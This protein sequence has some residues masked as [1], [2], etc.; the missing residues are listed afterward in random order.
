MS[1]IGVLVC[2]CGLA[3][4]TCDDPNTRSTGQPAATTAPDSSNEQ[5]IRAASAAF[6]RAYNA[7]DV[8]A[9]A[10]LFTEDAEC[11]DEHG[12]LISG[13]KS[14]TENFAAKPGGNMEVEIDSIRFLTPEV[15]KEEGR[16]TIKPDGSGPPEVSR[17]TVL[18]VH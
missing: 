15:A 12:N 17:Y 6:V 7:G 18:Y 16:C 10:T 1:F 9:L 3:L 4:G 13:T 5:A 11:A 2:G 14:I 8:K